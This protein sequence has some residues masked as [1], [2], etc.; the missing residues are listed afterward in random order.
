MSIYLIDTENVQTRFIQLIPKLSQNDSIILFMMKDKHHLSLKIDDA[1]AINKKNIEISVIDC[2][3]GK[4]KKNALDF[5]LVS[6]IG[7][8]VCNNRDNHQSLKIVSDDCGFDPVVDFWK[9]RGIDICRVNLNSNQEDSLCEFNF[10]LEFNLPKEISDNQEHI[11]LSVNHVT[12]PTVEIP[13]YSIGYNRTS[14]EIRCV[15]FYRYIKDALPFINKWVNSIYCT[16]SKFGSAKSNQFVEAKL[17]AY[18]EDGSLFKKYN[19]VD[20][21]PLFNPNNKCSFNPNNTCSDDIIELLFEF[22]DIIEVN[23]Q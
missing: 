18:K 14:G 12:T 15:E 4:A 19:L 2:F 3:S 10:V 17:Y 8:L 9:D 6:Y 7:Y 16:Y 1:I 23:K 22:E 21:R 5:Q 13:A 20:L 11:K